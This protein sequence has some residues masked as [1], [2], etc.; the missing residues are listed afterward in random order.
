MI[1]LGKLFEEA[2]KVLAIRDFLGYQFEMGNIE[3]LKK[4]KLYKY[5]VFRNPK[6]PHLW[7]RQKGKGVDMVIKVGGYALYIEDS[8]CSHDYYYRSDWFIKCRLKRFEN[9]RSDSRH[10][11][12]ILTNK[13]RNFRGVNQLAQANGIQII[14]INGL[15]QKLRDILCTVSSNIS[16]F[17][18]RLV[19]NYHPISQLTTKIACMP[20]ELD[21]NLLYKRYINDVSGIL[22][23]G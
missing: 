9:Y 3:V 14:T 7:K 19:S 16:K 13:P 20:I 1:D 4:Y 6:Q 21:T 23:F 18:N 8:F 12:L 10:I 11:R 2:E 17:S 15:L 22:S 5:V